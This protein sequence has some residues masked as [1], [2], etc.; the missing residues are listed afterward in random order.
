LSI[1]KEQQQHANTILIALFGS[2]MDKQSPT[3]ATVILLA[4]I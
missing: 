3:E 2:N 4:K 1:T